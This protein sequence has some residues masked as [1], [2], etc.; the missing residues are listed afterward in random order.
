MQILTLVPTLRNGGAERVV[1]NLTREW[2]KS[3]RVTIVL[4]DASDPRYEHGGRIVDFG[5]RLPMS[6]HPL[7]SLKKVGSVGV[8]LVRLIHLLRQE[9]P[10]RIFSFMEQSNFV[11]I[12]AAALTGYLDRL[13]VSVRVN[14][15]WLPS[16]HRILLRYLYR[17]PAQVIAVSEGVK[18]E[19]ESMQVPTTRISV[20]PNPIAKPDG[21]VIEPRSRSPLTNRF[22]LGVGRLHQQKGFDRLLAAY[23]GLG[24]PE[25]HL[26]ILGE[27]EQRRTLVSSAQEL[28]VAERVHFPG[29]VTEVETWYRNAACFVLSS[30]F[31][32]WPNVLVEAMAN[33][34]PVVSFDCQYGPSEIIE[35][36]RNGLLVPEGD[37]EGL[38]MA[39]ARVVDDEALRRN[40]VIKGLERTRAFDIEEIALCWLRATN[41]GGRPATRSG[42]VQGSQRTD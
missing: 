5:L 32:G 39:M 26:V 30:R 9:Q 29:W 36:G 13:H 2:A 19:L 41:A 35:D 4:F 6:D 8:L 14:P 31:E 34:C 24:Q 22:I 33:G 16:M 37:V 12:I 3:H 11:A 20:I 38:T 17:L 7:K 28:G 18:R 40:L 21:Q 1:S 15:S 25:L 42:P 27:G 10:D 23:R